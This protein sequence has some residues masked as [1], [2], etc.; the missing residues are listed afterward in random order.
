M[1]T[2]NEPSKLFRFELECCKCGRQKTVFTRENEL[3][4]VSCECGW[5]NY[6]VKVVKIDKNLEKKNY[7]TIF[8]RN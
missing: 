6:N 3:S 2:S 5:R 7:N 8:E 4:I 1:E